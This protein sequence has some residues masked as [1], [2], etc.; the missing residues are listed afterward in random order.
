LASVSSLSIVS[1]SVKEED[2]LV[3]RFSALKR[4]VDSTS[5]AYESHLSSRISTASPMAYL[6][7]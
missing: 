1:A 6:D 5:D 2:V 7:F 3:L 4:K